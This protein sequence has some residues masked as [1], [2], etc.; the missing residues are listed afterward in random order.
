MQ[1]LPVSILPGL[2]NISVQQ[3]ASRQNVSP[4]VIHTADGELVSGR[5]ISLR[6]LDSLLSVVY[7]ETCD[8]GAGLVQ[9]RTNRPGNLGLLGLLMS[10]A[11]SLRHC[12]DCLMTFKDLLVP[13]LY[14]ELQETDTLARLQVWSDGSLAFAHS[15]IHNDVVVAS[16]VAVA[17]A[18]SDN[19]LGLLSVGFRHPKPADVNAYE[20]FFESNLKFSNVA[21]ELVFRRTVLD[22]PLSSAS[23]DRH[24]RVRRYAQYSLQQ[25]Q[26]A[27]GV[28]GQ[29]RQRLDD[30][31]NDKQLSSI[32]AVAAALSMTSRTLQRRLN[33]EDTTFVKV[34]D[35]LRHQKAC[36]ALHKVDC[37]IEALANRLGFS[38]VANFYH[39][40]RR[41]QGVSPG[42][43]RRQHIVS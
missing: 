30:C 27:Q 7:A 2:F 41:W 38:E 29:V 33:Q 23:A 13:Y 16:V 26:R 42:R 22:R 25:L 6:Q 31:L 18:L 36:F 10:T 24:R 1:Q 39:A 3:K 37:D 4:Q 40:F 14:F 21:N 28:S 9:G 8:A 17:R 12:V 32:E 43:F 11:P 35:R 34:R 5:Y 19:A 15:R 20:S